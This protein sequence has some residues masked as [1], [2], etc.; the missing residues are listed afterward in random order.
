M[1][2]PDYSCGY[3]T[4]VHVIG[5]FKSISSICAI[6]LLVAL[7]TIAIRVIKSDLNSA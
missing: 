3:P 2:S 7:W 6:V 5:I 4:N 1:V